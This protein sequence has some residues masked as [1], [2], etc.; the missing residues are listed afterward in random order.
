MPRL[1]QAVCARCDHPFTYQEES[2]R[3]S[4][5]LHCTRCGREKSLGKN[6]VQALVDRQEKNLQ[7]SRAPGSYP[8]ASNK[9]RP[10]VPDGDLD[11]RKYRQMLEQAAG[12]CI[13]GA[14]FRFAAKPRCPVC[15]SSVYR[16]AGPAYR[17]L[18]GQGQVAGA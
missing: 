9:I 4:H 12:T 6:E 5:I 10:L 14:V 2:G 13:C 15:R 1:R 18:P 11:I 7:L 8:V 3:A 17:G 16:P